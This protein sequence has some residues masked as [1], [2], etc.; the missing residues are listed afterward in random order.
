MRK[1][2]SLL[3][4]LAMVLCC[5]PAMAEEAALVKTGLSLTATMSAARNGGVQVD[6]TLTAVTVDDNGVIDACV[7]D[8]VQAVIGFDATGALTTDPATTYASKNELGDAYG[9][10]AASAIGAEWNEQAA[11]FAAYCTGKTLDELKGMAVTEAMKPADADLAATV[12]LA[13]Y[14][15]LPGIEAAINNAQHLGAKKGDALYL[16]QLTN[17]SSS[18]SATAEAE[19]QAQ[20]YAT[21]AAITMNGDVITSCAIDAMQATVKFD[22]TGAITTDMSVAPK[23]KNQLGADYG[24]AKYSPIGKEWFEQAAG[25]AAYVT[26][27]TIAEVGGIAV[28]EG[29]YPTDA[30]LTATTTM[31][32]ADMIQLIQKLSK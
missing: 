10:R 25:F 2:I 20:A 19:G 6:F 13:T 29:G 3:L 1:L 5:I 16:P 8:N 24:M 26:G 22:A 4:C 31:G 21:V 12:T 11:A 17:A 30:D 32:V 23:T 15:F 28:N 9:M 14:N 18:K 27:K 7:I